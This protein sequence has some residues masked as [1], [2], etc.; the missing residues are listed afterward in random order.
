MVGR[1][2]IG[3]LS[4]IAASTITGMATGSSAALTGA[5]IEAILQATQ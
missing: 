3:L 5:A 4:L 2:L 1:M